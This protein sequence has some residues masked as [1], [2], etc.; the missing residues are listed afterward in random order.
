M[1]LVGL[2]LV[3][4]AQLAF[5]TTLVRRRTR[6]TSYFH[7]AV[8]AGIA[9]AAGGAL[10]RSGPM[11]GLW[12]ALAAGAAWFAITWRELGLAK[13]GLRVKAGERLPAFT[14]LTT[15]NAPVGSDEVLARAPALIV[16]YRGWW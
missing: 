16:L 6:R 2:A 8:V 7:A 14:A 15:T 11:W 12:A 5:L 1:T 9:L 3:A 13:G 10:A 4:V